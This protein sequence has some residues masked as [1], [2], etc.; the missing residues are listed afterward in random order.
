MSEFNYRGVAWCILIALMFAAAVWVITIPAKAEP[1]ESYVIV[2][3][4]TYPYH[5]P[6]R[7][8]QGQT[9]YVNDTI[10]I[11]GMGHGKLQL[12]WYGKYSEYDDPQYVIK[13][14]LFKRELINFWLDPAVF[15]ER[16]GRWFQYYGN[17]TERNG[18]LIAFKVSDR[19]RNVTTP[20]NNVTEDVV[21]TPIYIPPL[22]EK[23]ITDYLVARGDDLTINSSR[24]WIFGT[25][26][27][28]Y[29]HGGYFTAD[30]IQ[31]LEIGSYKVVLQDPGRNA[32]FEVNY[33]AKNR[34]LTSPWKNVPDESVAGSQPMLDIKK[35]YERIK[36]TDD[37]VQTFDLEV[38]LPEVYVDRIDEVAVGSRI[39]I[40][41]EP[42][43]TLLDV[44]GYTNSKNESVVT[45]VLD[46]DDQTVRTIA[47][48]SY[49]STAIRENPGSMSSYQVYIPINKNQ[50]PNGIHTVKVSTAIGSSMLHDFP[51]SEMPA[52][53]FVP[54]ATLKYIGDRN[55][56]VPTPTPE[57][58]VK[59]VEVPVTQIVTVQMTPSETQISDA[60]KKL[61]DRQNQ[62]LEV[63]AV[64]GAVMLLALAFIGWFAYSIWR[65][66][67]KKE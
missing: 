32:I 53:S 61:I 52:D 45:A 14:S 5:E 27:G 60:A 48:N 44:R 62:E 11:A 43:M 59:S 1:N 51:V 38:Q 56:W 31:D 36:A 35:F 26:D 16:T 47:K 66:R 40:A 6:Y 25:L 20:F 28:I 29:A 3:E 10:D 49:T 50:M 46:P 21:K 15:S 24:V 9:V 67:G 18:N 19:K 37:R 2:T 7:I 39:P 12:A 34:L 13:T 42:G 58:V 17:E 41:Y 4:D 33:D 30:E 23:H 63:V 54:N 22:P 65:A 57:I 8:D 64:I 55:P